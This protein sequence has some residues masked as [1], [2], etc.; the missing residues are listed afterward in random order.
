MPIFCQKCRQPVPH[1][2]HVTVKSR[3][4]QP[5]YSYYFCTIECLRLYYNPE[6]AVADDDAGN[7]VL[8]LATARTILEEVI[9][10]ALIPLTVYIGCKHCFTQQG[11]GH[12]VHCLVIR[13]RKLLG[14]MA[15]AG[16]ED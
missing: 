4:D 12:K 2:A 10:K 14:E 9:N 8:L 6:L 13:A 15:Q 7:P 1:N 3:G 5:Y 16:Y 11:E